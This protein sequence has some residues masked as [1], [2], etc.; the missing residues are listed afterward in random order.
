MSTKFLSL[1]FLFMPSHRIFLYKAHSYFLLCLHPITFMRLRCISLMEKVGAR[2]PPR[3]IRARRNI[4]WHARCSR[5]SWESESRSSN[6]KLNKNTLIKA[7]RAVRG[8]ARAAAHID[9]GEE[10]HFKFR[11]CWFSKVVIELHWMEMGLGQGFPSILVD[12][13]R[14]YFSHCFLQFSHEIPK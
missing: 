8:A 5:S 10:R 3:F 11:L 4:C 14:M 6:C 9:F 1:N 2:L 13:Y 7:C 12:Y